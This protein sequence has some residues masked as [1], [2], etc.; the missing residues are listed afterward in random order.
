MVAVGPSVEEATEDTARG[1]ID[2]AV[3]RTSLDRAEPN[4]LLS[5]IDELWVGTSS[6]RRLTA[7]LIQHLHR[8]IDADHLEAEMRGQ[9]FG[10]AS[11]PTTEIDDQ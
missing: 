1:A 3:A 2:F 5:I 7:S 10:K 11:G 9:Q 6:A 4:M 8:G